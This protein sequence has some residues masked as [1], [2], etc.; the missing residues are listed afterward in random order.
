MVPGLLRYRSFIWRHARADLRHR[1]AGTGMGLAW[2]VVHPLAVIAVY[3]VVFTQV[4]RPAAAPSGGGHLPYTL[5]LCSGFFPWLAFSDCVTRGCGAFLANAAYL[6]KLPIPEPVFVAQAAVASTLSLG[7]NFALL[8]VV[9]VCLGWRPAWTWLLLPI[10]LVL[11]Q[12]FGFGV[13]LLLGTLNVFFRDVAEWVGIAL[14]LVFWTVPIVYKL[15]AV[16]HWVTAALLW[17]PLGPPLE[18]VRSLFLYRALPPAADWIGMT[19]WPIA[20]VALAAVV[21]RQLRHEIRDLI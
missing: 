7:V 5:Y 12:T 10:P 2:N 9:A 6:K 8:G 14:Q 18:A 15:D 19:A 1:Y 17:H 21:L 16:P 13:G 3:S 4:F 20:A 11:L